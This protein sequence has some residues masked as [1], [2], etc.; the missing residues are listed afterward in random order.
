MIF[1]D[2]CFRG[3]KEAHI[4]PGVVAQKAGV[5]TV[6]PTRKGGEKAKNAVI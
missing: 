5:Y 6:R 1:C 2:G 4:E 3:T